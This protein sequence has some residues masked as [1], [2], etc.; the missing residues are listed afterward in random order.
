MET[1]RT[2]QQTLDNVNA[3]PGILA[4]VA[5]YRRDIQAMVTRGMALR[6]EFFVNAFDARHQVASIL[7]GA[8]SVGTD[9]TAREGRHGAFV[10]ELA[11]AVSMFQD[12]TDTLLSMYTGLSKLID[13]LGT[14]PPQKSIFESI[15]NKI[16]KTIDKLNLE[17]Y[18]NLENWVKEIDQ[19]VQVQLLGRLDELI[20]LWCGEFTKVAND[21]ADGLAGSVVHG[22]S[23]VTGRN[24]KNG[25]QQ[26]KLIIEQSRHEIRL[27]NQV[28]YLE[29]PVEAAKASWYAQLQTWLGNVCTLP[30]LKS[31][32][33]E[34]GVTAR[35]LD[36][37]ETSYINLVS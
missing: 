16:Q 28:I 29:P 23:A 34:I 37:E 31:S 9:F 6:W 2:Y 27:K 15:L 3:N 26:H 18:A 14:C 10:R 19:K 8:G 21:S 25:S 32:Q 4:L 22:S 7:P 13:E 11:S 20:D 33:Q 35:K 24:E 17:G 12:R 1:V 30:R 5:E 36:L